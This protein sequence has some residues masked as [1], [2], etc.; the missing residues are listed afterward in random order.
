M[1]LRHSHKSPG[2]L[3]YANFKFVHCSLKVMKINSSHFSIGSCITDPDKRYGSRF[4][5]L[6][7][8]FHPKRNLPKI[9]GG[10]CMYSRKEKCL[11]LVIKTYYFNQ[12]INQL[13]C[14]YGYWWC[15]QPTIRESM[16]Q[17]WTMCG[18]VWYFSVLLHLWWREWCYWWSLPMYVICL[19]SQPKRIKFLYFFFA[20]LVYY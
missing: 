7:V 9:V 1:W 20:Q 12:L 16:L 10:K 2:H 13:Y 15:M 19:L 5:D 4:R 8:Y 3:D 17:W 11:R 14:S 6:N 18:Q